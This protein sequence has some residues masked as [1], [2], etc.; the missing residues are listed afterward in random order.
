[1]VLISYLQ[2]LKTRVVCSLIY[3]SDFQEA[4]TVTNSK[5]T[6]FEHSNLRSPTVAPT[7]LISADGTL[8]HKAK[9]SRIKHIS[10][11]KI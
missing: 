1:M 5:G 9:K 10:L 4:F 7:S 2:L 3:R 6:S 11:V 8:T